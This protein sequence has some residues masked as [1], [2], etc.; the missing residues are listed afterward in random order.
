MEP[1]PPESEAGAEP[2]AA[3]VNGVDTRALFSTIDAIREDPSKGLCQF[4]ATTRWEHGT[5]SK[6]RAVK[7]NYRI[8]T[9]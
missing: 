1:T 2:Q 3:E 5:V 9:H 4:F 8:E 7:V 6:T